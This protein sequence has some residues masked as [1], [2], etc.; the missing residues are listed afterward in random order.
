[1]TR[2]EDS[3]ESDYVTRGEFRCRQ[4]D[5]VRTRLA[6]GQHWAAAAALLQCPVGR[7]AARGLHAAE[8]GSSCISEYRRPERDR[9]YISN[10][11]KKYLMYREHV[12]FFNCFHV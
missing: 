8:L 10:R 2:V 4:P 9:R 5:S 6:W 12:R 7:R 3:V 11:G 1:M